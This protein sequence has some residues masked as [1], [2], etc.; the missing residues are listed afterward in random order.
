MFKVGAFK[1]ES[2]AGI[3]VRLM[4]INANQSLPNLSC[5]MYSRSSLIFSGLFF[6]SLLY[7]PCPCD[8]VTAA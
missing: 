6:L 2:Q 5:A 3:C 1:W 4:C 7:S 8:A